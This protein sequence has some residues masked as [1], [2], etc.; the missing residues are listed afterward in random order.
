MPVEIVFNGEPHRL[1]APV[2]LERLLR[3]LEIDPRRCAVERNR[4]IVRKAEYAATIVQDG[5]TLEVV[6]LVGGG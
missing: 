4:V 3:D 6:T 5:D 1:P 2:S